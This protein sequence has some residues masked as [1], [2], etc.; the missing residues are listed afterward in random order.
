M[1]ALNSGRIVAMHVVSSGNGWGACH[2]SAELELA[3]HSG[4]RGPEAVLSRP[5]IRYKK[6]H[7]S[8]SPLATRNAGPPLRLS[9]STAV[10][11]W[12]QLR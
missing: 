3:N 12:T 11:C 9:Q 6:I 8:R 4:S 10:L 1:E 7:T 5:C 2:S